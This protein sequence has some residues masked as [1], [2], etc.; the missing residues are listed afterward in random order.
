MTRVEGWE[1]RLFAAIDAAGSR[2][3]SLTG[4][5]CALFTADCVHAIT[6]IDYAAAYRD[7]SARR[8]KRLARD[9]IDITTS[10]LGSPI[11][12]RLAQRG[13][14]VALIGEG[15]DALGVCI[16]DRVAMHTRAGVVAVPLSGA[17]C[18]WQVGR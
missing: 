16:G 6:G 17:L 1:S 7:V 3:F 13:D 18:A 9:L 14:V 4:N 11:C 10:L 2:P 15:G 5:S 8:A 12:H